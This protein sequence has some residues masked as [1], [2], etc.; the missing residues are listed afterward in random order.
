MDRHGMG[1]RGVEARQGWGP[2]PQ[3][4]K[5]QERRARAMVTCSSG[6]TVHH[7]VSFYF[8]KLPPRSLQLNTTADSITVLLY[9]VIC[10]LVPC[11]VAANASLIPAEGHDRLP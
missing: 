8:C 9:K 4:V 7:Y 2:R 10:D 1:D 5:L 3:P 6:G 11:W